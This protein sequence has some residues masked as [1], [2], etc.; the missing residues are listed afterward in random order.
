[1][2]RRTDVTAAWVGSDAF[3]SLDLQNL[4]H[5]AT[6]ADYI[7]DGGKCREFIGT[8]ATD[9]EST[10]PSVAETAFYVGSDRFV[11][12]SGAALWSSVAPGTVLFA[13]ACTT[14]KAAT[15]VGA[16]RVGA[17]GAYLGWDNYVRNEAARVAA[18]SFYFGTFEQGRRVG[19]VYANLERLRYTRSSRLNKASGAT[20]AVVLKSTHTAEGT[21]PRLRDIVELRDASGK[22]LVDGD[23]LTVSTAQGDG[24]PDKVTLGLQVIGLEANERGRVVELKLAGEAFGEVPVSSGVLTSPYA[25]ELEDEVTLPIDTDPNELYILTATMELPEGGLTQFDVA[26]RFVSAPELV[27]RYDLTLAF[28]DG[29]TLATLVEGRI[30]LMWSASANT[31]VGKGVIDVTYFESPLQDANDGC[32][33]STGSRPGTLEV[34]SL[35]VPGGELVPGRVPTRMEFIVSPFVATTI[36]NC[37]GLNLNIPDALAYGI[38]VDNRLDDGSLVEG[39][40]RIIA[41]AF[42][43]GVEPEA[44]VHTFIVDG[45]SGDEST[46]EVTTLTVELPE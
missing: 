5:V 41:D 31:Y 39:S 36:L 22:R 30:P 32:K 3:G 7:C 24:E 42:V 2:Q 8:G 11:G 6:H 20:E 43:P 46:F 44:G 4:V 35:D 26:V 17:D 29:L 19:D 21:G 37:D 15:P 34:F 13:N 10:D 25:I 28:T 27:F 23:T 38:F 1:V 14:Y 12:V 40:G 9:S 16:G 18:E 45:V 33:V